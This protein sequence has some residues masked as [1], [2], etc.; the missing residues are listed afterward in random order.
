MV[1]PFSG[2]KSSEEQSQWVELAPGPRERGRRRGERFSIK[3][4]EGGKSRFQLVLWVRSGGNVMWYAYE[5][6]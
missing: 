6:S 2:M 5:V 3:K 4:T 1:V